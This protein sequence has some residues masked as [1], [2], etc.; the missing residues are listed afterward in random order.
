MIKK[1][2]RVRFLNATG[3]GIVTRIDEKNNLV[4]V[5][6]EDG[7]EIPTLTRDCV[8]IP[9][10]NENTNFPKKNF[11]SKLQNDELAVDSKKIQNKLVEAPEKPLVEIIETAEGDILR[12]FLAFVPQDIKKL[13]TTPYILYLVNDSNYF[14]YYNIITRKNDTEHVSFSQGSIEPNILEEIGLLKKE[15]L[16]NWSEIRT[17]IIAFKQ[18]KSYQP[19]NVIDATLK[20]DLVKFYKLHSFTENDFFEAEAMIIDIISESRK[21]KLKE[22]SPT[23]IKNAI[24][25]KEKTEKPKPKHIVTLKKPEIIEVDL[26]INELV[27]TTAGLSNADMLQ[28]QLDK[29][30]NTLAEYKNKKGQKIVFIHGKG[31]G[32]LRKEIEKLLKTR[33]KNYYFQDASFREYGFGATMVTIK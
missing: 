2:D 9:Q 8:V 25:I 4:Y 30:N 18:I 33:Y 12:V 28:L 23:E 3:G 5:E 16:N 32:V 15:D 1:G 19:Q 6:D 7:F 11:S 24:L 21:E 17:Q 20:I 31:E 22:I 13:Q 26:H 29:F 14:L 27:D 10:I